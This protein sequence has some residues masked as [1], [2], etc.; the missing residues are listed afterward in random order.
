MS[1]LSLEKG[2]AET[3]DLAISLS[4]S[5]TRARLIV[6]GPIADDES[7]AQLDR[8][9][10]QLGSLFEYRGPVGDQT[11]IDFF[12]EI[13]HFVFPT[14]YKHE[15]VPLVLYEAMASGV[16]CVATSQGSINEQLEGSPS[17]LAQDSDSFVDEILPHLVGSRASNAASLSARQAYLRA[18]EES[19]RQLGRFIAILKNPEVSQWPRS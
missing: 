11:K 19:Q 18:L 12:G 10:R 15:A 14:R 17:L 9:R 4:R 7:R 6:A 8:A 16:V 5:G 13:T 1:N 2:I 3:V